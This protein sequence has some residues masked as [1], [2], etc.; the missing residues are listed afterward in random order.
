MA[1]AWLRGVEPQHDANDSTNDWE[2][3]C[4]EHNNIIYQYLTLLLD[5]VLIEDLTTLGWAGNPQ[6]S[7]TGGSFTG[8]S[9]RFTDTA[10]KFLAGMVG[11]FVVIRDDINEEN[12]GIYLVTG[13][14]DA[15]NIDIE[16]YA[17]GGVFPTAATGLSW[18]MLDYANAPVTHSTNSK[19]QL[20]VL[21]SPHATS[22]YT[23]VICYM[24][25]ASPASGVFSAGS[26][27]PG[28]GIQ[29][30][31]GPASENWDL[32]GHDWSVLGK[33]RLPP[34]TAPDY[35]TF[36]STRGRVD[37]V[38]HGRIFA[39]GDQDGS[40]ISIYT[41]FDGGIG[42][43][44]GFTIGVIDPLET[45]PTHDPK[46]L[47]VISGP[48]HDYEY[49]NVLYR[50]G[51]VDSM[52]RSWVY[53]RNGNSPKPAQWQDWNGR[54]GDRLFALSL[55]GPN[56]YTGEYDGLPIHVFVDP[57]IDTGGFAMLGQFNP[58]QMV[59]TTALYLGALKTFD[60]HQWLHT[61]FGV[62]WAWPGL[63]LYF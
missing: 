61:S 4:R 31:P 23:I 51:G 45:T 1:R 2:R 50:N 39:F 58:A 42:N 12:T 5:F 18:W 8:S 11:E 48:N 38:D 43:F 40:F 52:D 26:Q 55:T 56:E 17:G 19:D 28:L 63:P 27:R 13:F 14:I 10:G 46:E 22:P 37:D 35:G 9:L 34:A 32:V 16:F 44:G 47:V 21:E 20:A 62:A 53:T 6:A 29:I 33:S 54:A 41:K 25:H 49:N 7:D 59:F 3:V 15:N 57:N 30:A 60:S 36:G 24:S